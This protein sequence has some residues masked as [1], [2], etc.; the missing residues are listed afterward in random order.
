MTIAAT[1]PHAKPAE[2]AWNGV[3]EDTARLLSAGLIKASDDLGPGNHW[4]MLDLEDG[5]T[6]IVIVRVPR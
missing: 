5:R 6:A 3:R 2:G 4:I 1:E